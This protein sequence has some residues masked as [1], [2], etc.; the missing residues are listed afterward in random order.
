MHLMAAHEGDICF[1]SRES[2]K[3]M[4]PEGAVIK[5]FVI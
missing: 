5:R 1:V 2:Q 4:F 3:Q